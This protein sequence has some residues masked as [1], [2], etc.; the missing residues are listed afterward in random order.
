TGG[1]SAVKSVLA[2]WALVGLSL[3]GFAPGAGAV[4]GGFCRISGKIAFRP[5]SAGAGQWSI[6]D[7]VIDCAGLLS[8]GKNRMLGPGPVKGSGSY[9]PLAAVGGACLHQSGSGTVEYRIPTSGGYLV[10][11]EPDTF[12]MVGVGALTTPTLRGAFEIAPPYGGDCV[13]KPVTSA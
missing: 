3:V 13:T 10:I 12:T 2:G 7:G 6:E 5:Q 9:S 8:G 11:S 1:E 4:G